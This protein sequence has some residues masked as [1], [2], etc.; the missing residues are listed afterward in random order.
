MATRA[1][2]RRTPPPNPNNTAL[3]R[4]DVEPIPHLRTLTLFARPDRTRSLPCRKVYSTAK[5]LW[6]RL[7]GDQVPNYPLEPQLRTAAA[8]P[9][10]V[11]AQSPC[12]LT[13]APDS[14]CLS[15]YEVPIMRPT[16]EALGGVHTEHA[17]VLLAQGWSCDNPRLRKFQKF[18]PEYRHRRSVRACICRIR[19]ITRPHTYALRA[20]WCV[21]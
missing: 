12:A 1:R 11:S 4:P 20:V 9:A 7:D 16:P 6:L 17:K 18:K 5:G 2:P 8:K 3:S 10:K 13:T 19:G 14:R 21:S 15:G